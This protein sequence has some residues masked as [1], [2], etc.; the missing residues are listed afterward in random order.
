MAENL[1]V[2][3][4]KA[5]AIKAGIRGRD[6]LDLALLVCDKSAVA[7]G[8]FT[9]NLVK[10]APVL[11]DMERVATGQARA[12]LVN[13]S[14]AN[15]CTGAEGL[16]KAKR[17][18][19]LAA[20]E[21]GC[22]PEEV[23]VCS[24]GVIGEQLDTNCFEKHMAPL[25]QG[26]RPEG[27][28]EVSRAIMTTDTV[29]KTSVREVVLGGVPVRLI[30]LAKGAGMIKPNMATMLAFVLTDVVIEAGLLQEMLAE[31]GSR[32]F[33]RITIDGDT[34]TNDSLIILANGLAGNAPLTKGSQAAETFRTALHELV[35]DLALQIVRDGEGATKLITIRVNGAANEAEAMLAADT[36]A[37]SKLVKTAF[38]GEDANWGRIIA[39]LGRSGANFDQL[40]VDIAFDGVLMV[41]EGL[42]QGKERE[43]EATKVLKQREFAVNID[44]HQGNGAWEV[45]TCDL[46]IDYVKINADYRS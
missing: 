38:F 25:V 2:K 46:S 31:A 19:E 37:E 24:T 28:V 17:C 8:I 15:A 5:A 10:A 29:P 32:S 7:A 44:L 42:G 33:N 36:V 12:I 35:L 41:K 23:L 13:A 30:G 43:A 22:A 9:T 6:R 39:A 34:S 16:V 40:K 26:L 21:L 18:A 1:Q 14:I 3:G 11:L 20:A 4:F 27:F 45:Y